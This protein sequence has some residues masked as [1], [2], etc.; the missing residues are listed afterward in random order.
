MENRDIVVIGAS[1]GGVQALVKLAQGLPA[2]L[3][4]ALFVVVHVTADP[5]SRLAEILD[6][7]GPLPAESPHDRQPIRPG[8]IYVAPSD[9]HLLVDRSRVYLSRGPRENQMRPA[10]DPLFRSAAVVH[11]AQAIG[12]V[13]TG[14]MDD[15]TS[16]MLAIKQ[17]GGLAVVQ[18]P[19]D[20]E[21]PSMPQSVFDA[22]E[23]DYRVVLDDLAALLVRLTAEPSGPPSPPPLELLTEVEIARSGSSSPELMQE[24]GDLAPYA[25]AECGGPLWR[26]RDGK[27][28]RFRCHTGHAYTARTL[29][30]A[31]PETAESSLW[32]ALRV[33]E[34]RTR[35]LE[36]LGHDEQ[37]QGRHRSAAQMLERAQE[38]RTHSERLRDLLL[39]LGRQ[40]EETAA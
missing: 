2:D 12:V 37:Q 34:E 9:H 6:R 26:I 3:P 20:A 40:G 11:G 25:C 27:M 35:M 15:G 22:M 33:M 5:P 17:C 31:M 39:T 30:A 29:V 38:S 4:A 19:A 21:Q 16:G 14:T 13:L 36:R 7:S 24:I 32:A 28:T 18:D 10:I 8:R 1:A 23:V